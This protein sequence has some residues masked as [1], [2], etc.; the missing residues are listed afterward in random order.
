M[1][2]CSE[3]GSI[4]FVYK[5][6]LAIIWVP[7]WL[8]VVFG[9][10]MVEDISVYINVILIVAII[11]SFIF[12]YSEIK[13]Y[14]YSKFTFDETK[15]SF[16]YTNSKKRESTYLVKECYCYREGGLSS[17]IELYFPDGEYKKIYGYS[18]NLDVFVRFIDTHGIT[19]TN[20]RYKKA[21]VRDEVGDIIAFALLGI[22]LVALIGG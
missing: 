3:R 2:V 22:V 7:F 20:K 5:F 19:Y 21:K 10:N 13:S 17:F 11:V 16:F 12:E 1:I 8:I 14:L 6:L 18:K 9:L 15:E 4:A